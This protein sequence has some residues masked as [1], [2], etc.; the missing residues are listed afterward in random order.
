METF[1]VFAGNLY[2]ELKNRQNKISTGGV[3][4]K[5]A[6][7]EEWK[8]ITDRNEFKEEWRKCL[9]EWNIKDKIL[10]APVGYCREVGN[11]EIEEEKIVNNDIEESQLGHLQ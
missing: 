6:E 10:E 5:C 4:W 11:H 8:E 7:I 9:K 1:S 3:F 2:R